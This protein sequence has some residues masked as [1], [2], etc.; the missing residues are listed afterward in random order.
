[1]A[2]HHHVKQFRRPGLA[3]AFILPLIL[4]GCGGK[5]AEPAAVRPVRVAPVVF[6]DIDAGRS[7]TGTVVSRTEVQAGFRAGGRIA[8]RLVDVGDRV[9]AGQTLARLDPTDLDLSLASAGARLAQAD[10]QAVQAVADLKR[11]TPLLASGAVSQAQ[12]DR[13]R[14]AADAATAQR[15]EA[16]SALDLA[17]N[18]RSYGA[19][20]LDQGGVVT[21]VLAD[22]GQVVSTGQTVL[23]IATDLGREIAI[24]VAEADLARLKPGDVGQAELWADARLALSATIREITPMADAASRTFRVRLALPAEAAD[25]VRLGMTAKVA[26]TDPSAPALALL[27]SSA[28]FQQGDKPAV[29][30][31]SPT[32]DRVQLRPVEVAAYRSDGVVVKSGVA[33]GDLVV[34]AGAH[35]LD[36]NLPVRVWDGGLP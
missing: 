13:V 14:A 34:T 1:M 29:W 7:F 4:A 28:L 25:K 35:R 17:R 5:E 30:V 2:G 31:L 11:Y 3:L 18:Q 36:A 20:T 21:A 22:A 24:D 26:F 8:A 27:P 10:A 16:A 32:R 12:Y 23:R 19:L 6:A 33:N 9:T 15:R